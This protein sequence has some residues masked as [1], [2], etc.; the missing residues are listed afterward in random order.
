MFLT[1]ENLPE[2]I[3]HIYEIPH[4]QE[5]FEEAWAN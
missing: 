4:F 5:Q 3:S 2:D 1:A